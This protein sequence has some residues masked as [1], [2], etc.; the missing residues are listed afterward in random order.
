MV[1]VLGL[2][3]TLRHNMAYIE[4]VFILTRCFRFSG[5]PVLGVSG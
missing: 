1:F 2:S 4:Q 3:S 5:Y